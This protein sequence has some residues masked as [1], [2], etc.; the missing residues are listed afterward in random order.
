MDNTTHS[1]QTLSFG[2]PYQ[3]PIPKE[4]DDSV[5]VP[6]PS[7]YI[8]YTFKSLQVKPFTGF[9]MSKFHKAKESSSLK[10]L[11]DAATSCIQGATAN[12]LTMQDFQWLLYYLRLTSLSNRT[13]NFVA[14]CNHSDHVNKVVEGV[15]PEDTLRTLEAMR[16]PMLDEQALQVPTTPLPNLTSLQ[17]VPG[18]LFMQDLI[19]YEAEYSEPDEE[20]DWLATRAFHLS[21]VEGK[22]NLPLKVR[23]GV[24]QKLSPEAI[25]ELETWV[26]AISNYGVN[27]SIT[28]TCGECGQKITTK[29]NISAHSFCSR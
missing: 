11:V 22:A 19:D 15:L 3:Q 9:Q 13:Y 7:K 12:E 4:L 23:V 17:V 24:V 5:T 26:D 2:Q 29:V 25:D 16:M 6:L 18:H 10:D 28:S 20:I 1:V 27:E 8:P 21:S 14:V